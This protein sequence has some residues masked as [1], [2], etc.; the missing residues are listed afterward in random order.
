MLEQLLGVA[1]KVRPMI[2]FLILIKS[3]SRS[4][5]NFSKSD[6][7]FF[8]NFPSVDSIVSAFLLC[9]PINIAQSINEVLPLFQ[10]FPLNDVRPE[11]QL[12]NLAVVLVLLE[13]LH[14][15]AVDAFQESA[16]DVEQIL[17]AASRDEYF[18][19]LVDFV[20]SGDVR[21]DAKLEV[22][23]LVQSSSIH[24]YF[25]EVSAEEVFSSAKLPTM[26]VAVLD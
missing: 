7:T 20:I 12:Q 15:T 24:D 16:E 9:L 18:P 19:V 11:M 10:S 1:W 22:I 17:I 13:E 14:P 6:R 23:V 2:L 21:L 5:V 8:V 4:V 3:F 26:L 25:V